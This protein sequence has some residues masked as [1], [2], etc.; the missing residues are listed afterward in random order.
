MRSGYRLRPVVLPRQPRLDTLV[1]VLPIAQMQQAG[2]IAMLAL[3][4]EVYTAGFVVTFQAQSYGAVEFIDEPPRLTIT[5]T[6]DRERDYWVALGGAAGEGAHSDWQW[7]HTYRC[8]PALP[9]DAAELSLK[10][11]AMRWEVPDLKRQIYVPVST[12]EGP[13]AFTLSLP[14]APP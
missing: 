14:L 13:W 11:I 3:S 7:R 4:L 2:G 5:V 10:I 12:I 9:P 8:F 1:H 6:D